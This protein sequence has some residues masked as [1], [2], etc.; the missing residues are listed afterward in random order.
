MSADLLKNI[1]DELRTP[2][3][4]LK[5][6]KDKKPAQTFKTAAD[7]EAHCRTLDHLIAKPDVA[8]VQRIVM[9]DEHFIYID[10][11]HVRN[12][13]TDETEPWALQLIETLNS[14]TERSL[15]APH[16]SS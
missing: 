7:K 10:L 8:L 1:P 15:S 4:W 6:T 2:K 12:V 9:K 14:Y 3:L 11:D 13:E 16:T 5:S